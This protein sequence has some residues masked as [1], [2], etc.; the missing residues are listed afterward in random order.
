VSGGVKFLV[1]RTF[2]VVGIYQY[3]TAQVLKVCGTPGPTACLKMLCKIC[4]RKKK[5]I[6]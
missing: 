2:I 1:S 5:K 4:L 6:P 3:F